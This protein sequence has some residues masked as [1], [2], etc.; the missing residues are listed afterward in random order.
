M[1][2]LTTDDRERMLRSRA[3]PA[4]FDMTHALH[5]PFGSQ[6]PQ[7]VGTPMP[8][9]GTYGPLGERSGVKPLTLDTLRRMPEYEPYN[10]HQ[11][12][13]YSSPTGITPAMGAFGFT[14]PQSATDTMSP[15]SVSSAAGNYTYHTQESP[16]RFPFPLSMNTHSGY[17]AQHPHMPR[18]HLHDRFNRPVGESAGSPLRTSMSYSGLGSSS[19]QQSQERSSSFSEHS[20]SMQDRPH[21]HRSLTQPTGGAPA[22]IGLGFSCKLDV[23][24]FRVRRL[25]RNRH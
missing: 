17:P 1:K 10:Q 16:R 3:L 2:R 24:E 18:L 12:Q 7:N 8:S 11:Q 25:T 14:P 15:A 22:P 13:Q 4:D 20:S 5:A 19:Q 23:S 9:P 6:P 21:Q